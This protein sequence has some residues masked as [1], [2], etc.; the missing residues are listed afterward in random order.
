MRRKEEKSRRRSNNNY[1]GVA[2]LLWS[3]DCDSCNEK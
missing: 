1:F 2:R 3:D